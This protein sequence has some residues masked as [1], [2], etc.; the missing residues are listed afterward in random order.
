MQLLKT[1]IIC[2]IQGPAR[3]KMIR[4]YKGNF[5]HRMTQRQMS[6]IFHSCQHE[7]ISGTIFISQT[8][9]WRRYLLIDFYPTGDLRMEKAWASPA[10]ALTYFSRNVPILAPEGLIIWTA[11]DITKHV[12]A[13]TS[14]RLGVYCWCGLTLI[15]TGI[16][17][18]MPSKI[19]NGINYSFPI[20]TIEFW[21]WIRNSSHI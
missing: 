3:V 21:E 10:V 6:K 17:D 13:T 8:L 11:F 5:P 19:W 18:H 20:C 9:R 12:Y 14:L 4:M 1:N 2:A 7:F 16:N 15:P